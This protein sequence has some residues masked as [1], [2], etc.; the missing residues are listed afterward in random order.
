MP[1]EGLLKPINCANQSDE[2]RGLGSCTFISFSQ[3]RRVPSPALVHRTSE[4]QTSHLYLFPSLLTNVHLL[5]ILLP[6]EA[7]LFLLLHGLA[8]AGNGPVAAARHD[9]LGPA[10]PA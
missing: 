2:G 9:N 8:A 3:Q 1:V 7:L 5:P 6:P 10:L 4:P